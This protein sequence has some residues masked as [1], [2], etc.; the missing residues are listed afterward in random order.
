ME[1][2]DQAHSKNNEIIAQKVEELA[3]E[4]YKNEI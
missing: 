4:D 1:A 3:K 2:Y